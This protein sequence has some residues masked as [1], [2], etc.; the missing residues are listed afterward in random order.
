MDPVRLN[1][2]IISM[3][4]MN[5]SAGGVQRRALSIESMSMKVILSAAWESCFPPG[6]RCFFCACFLCLALAVARFSAMIGGQHND[7]L[8]VR[9]CFL[10]PHSPVPS[11]WLVHFKIRT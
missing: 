2:L 11:S 10:D 1:T 9:L 3:Y 8:L 4:Y 6:T 7:A 5:S